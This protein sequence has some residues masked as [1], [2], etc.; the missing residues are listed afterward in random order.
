MTAR[1]DLLVFDD[2]IASGTYGGVYAYTPDVLNDALGLYDVIACEALLDKVTVSGAGSFMLYLQHSADNRN[3]VFTNGLITPPATPE[4]N[5]TSLS[6]IS[7]N[8]GIAAYQG[9]YPLLG[10]VRFALQF[11][12][13]TTSAHVKL[14][15]MLRDQ[16]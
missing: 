10:K 8:Y 4:I 2:Y 6:T 12:E 3:F 11:G 7:T 13:S 9:T 16:A 15:V 1:A 5:L 14:F